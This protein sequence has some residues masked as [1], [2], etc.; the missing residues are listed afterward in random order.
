V[1]WFGALVGPAAAPMILG[2]LPAFR[3]SGAAAAIGSWVAGMAVYALARTVFQAGMAV[4]VA[5]PVGVSLLV[6]M[7]AG[8]LSRKPV[9][10]RVEALMEA[11]SRDA[12]SQTVPSSTAP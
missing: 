6:F 9:P 5:A 11:L 10:A 12:A 2:L 8:W 1:L 7:G 4:T 3:R